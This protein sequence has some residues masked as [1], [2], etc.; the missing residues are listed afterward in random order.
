MELEENVFSLELLLRASVCQVAISTANSTLKFEIQ[1]KKKRVHLPNCV[2]RSLPAA[3]LEISLDGFLDGHGE[4]L[5]GLRGREECDP[6]VHQELGAVP[7]TGVGHLGLCCES[8]FLCVG[9]LGGW[10][11]ELRRLLQSEDEGE[12]RNKWRL[13]LEVRI[14]TQK[15]QGLVNQSSKCLGYPSVSHNH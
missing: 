8:W 9:V 5:V 7:V 14:Y 3:F 10:R 2:K 1:R 6:E 15:G 4:R 12:K 11:C 13:P